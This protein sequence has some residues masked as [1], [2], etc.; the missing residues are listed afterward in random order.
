MYLSALIIGPKW[1]QTELETHALLL[2]VWTLS[3]IWT[4]QSNSLSSSPEIKNKTKDQITSAY[5]IFSHLVE[6]L[7]FY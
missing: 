2:A 4:G 5:I 1:K 6:F 7:E 3:I